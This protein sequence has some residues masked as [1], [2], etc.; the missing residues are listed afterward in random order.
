MTSLFLKHREICLYLFF[1]VLTTAVNVAVYFVMFEVLMLP[2][3]AS[4]IA[5]QVAAILF[6]YITN[7]IWVFRS[8]GWRLRTLIFEIVSFFGCRMASA[9]FDVL[10]MW[11]TVDLLSWWPL[12]MKIIANVVVV[13]LNYVASK[14]LI[15]RK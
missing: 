15:F 10:F 12:W 13:I 3:V 2:N 11:V 7:K 1:G 4:S 6:A 5:A 9:A 14:Y 8:R